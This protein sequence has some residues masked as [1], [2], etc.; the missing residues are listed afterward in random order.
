MSRWMLVAAGSL[1]LGL[2][3]MVWMAPDTGPS[4]TLAAAPQPKVPAKVDRFERPPGFPP[5]PAP[6]TPPLR[7]LPTGDLDEYEPFITPQPI[8]GPEDP[9]PTDPDQ[10]FGADPHGLASAA[11]SR[12]GDMLDCVGA[13]QKRTGESGYEGR[14]TLKFTVSPAD[15]VSTEIVNGPEDP[16]LHGCLDAVMKGVQ[17]ERPDHDVSMMWPI[18]MVPT[19]E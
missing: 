19:P 5:P 4:V 12:R 14:F 18:P 11:V 8:R 15:G 2:V 17:F 1:A 7:E 9:K 13:Y 3:L 6:G 16:D 10:V